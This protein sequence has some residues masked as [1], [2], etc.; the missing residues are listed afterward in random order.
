MLLLSTSLLYD[1]QKKEQCMSLM[2]RINLTKNRIKIIFL[3]KLPSGQWT[4]TNMYIVHIHHLYVRGQDNVTI[5]MILKFTKFRCRR[6]IIYFLYFLSQIMIS[7]VELAA[8]CASLQYFLISEIWLLLMPK[9][10]KKK[11]NY[12]STSFL[13]ITR[14]MWYNS[15]RSIN[16]NIINFC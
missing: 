7:F 9:W 8:T 15:F 13:I 5:K 11:S 6:Q 12:S 1:I 14:R 4:Y 3:I 10:Y 2:G 16:L